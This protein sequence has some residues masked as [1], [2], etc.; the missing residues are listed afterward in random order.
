MEV[1]IPSQ[2]LHLIYIIIV[3][4]LGNLIPYKWKG[5]RIKK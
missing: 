1:F 3:G 2:F 4:T 5:R